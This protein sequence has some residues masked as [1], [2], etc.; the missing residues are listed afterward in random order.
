MRVTDEAF[1]AETSLSDPENLTL[2]LFFFFFF[3]FVLFVFFLV[4]QVYSQRAE[5]ELRLGMMHFFPGN[6]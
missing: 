4:L 1:L 6:L 5:N 3:F 2:Q